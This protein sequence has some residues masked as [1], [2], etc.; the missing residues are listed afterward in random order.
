MT[1]TTWGCAIRAVA[2]ASRSKRATSAGSAATRSGR[3]SFT[4]TSVSSVRCRAAQTTPIPPC[5]RGL[6]R[7]SLPAMTSVGSELHEGAASLSPARTLTPRAF[8]GPR[9][10]GPQSGGGASTP[11]RGTAPPRERRAPCA[12]RGRPRT[13]AAR[14]AARRRRPAR[15]STARSVST[16][17]RASSTGT[18]VSR[19]PWM[20][21]NGGASAWTRLIGEARSKA[22]A[23]SSRATPS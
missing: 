23:A 11:R 21:R 7:R 2:L 5:P 22:L 19:S 17:L 15:S 10:R 3:M 16:K 4:A 13:R 1:C 12:P 18:S 9:S 20:T 14:R 6:S 8:A